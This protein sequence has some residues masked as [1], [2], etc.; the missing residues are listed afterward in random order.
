VLLFVTEGKTMS[1]HIEEVLPITT[2]EIA[3]GLMQWG[4]S[5]AL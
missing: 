1:L 2:K 3:E 4:Y 5:C